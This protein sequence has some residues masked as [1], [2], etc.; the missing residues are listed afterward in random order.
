MISLLKKSGELCLHFKARI[1]RGAEL[2][3]EKPVYW[4]SQLK[5][6]LPQ[7]AKAQDSLEKRLQ[8]FSNFKEHDHN[9]PVRD[10]GFTFFGKSEPTLKAIKS[11]GRHTV[12]TRINLTEKYAGYTVPNHGWVGVHLPLSWRN[13]YYVNGIPIRHGDAVMIGDSSGYTSRGEDR[14]SIT[15]G[16][17]MEALGPALRALSANTES[18]IDI[19]TC[20]FRPSQRLI[21]ALLEQF[22]VLAGK[23][24]TLPDARATH[25]I[26]ETIEADLVDIVAQEILSM[27]EQNSIYDGRSRK[28]LDVVNEAQVLNSLTLG[29][30]PSLSELCA[31]TG[32][33]QTRLF[34][35][36]QEVH[37]LAPYQCLQAF[38]LNAAMERLTD[39]E[40]PPK[41]V[42]EVAINAGFTKSGRFAEAFFATFGVRPSDILNRTRT[43]H[44]GWT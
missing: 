15:F 14:I 44:G 27:S 31:A 19:P 34:E 6:A 8:T 23:G 33:G 43:V 20:H 1:F 32:V 30:M 4:R 41:S 40:N 3:A 35:C 7:F 11:A 38:R 39:N 18:L 28:A 2:F 17:H 10:S 29:R 16:I 12:A 9:M 37:G 13:I 26:Q 42:K 22:H 25:L 36:F 21:D 24:P 5:R